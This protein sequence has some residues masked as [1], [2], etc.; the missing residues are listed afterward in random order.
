MWQSKLPLPAES[1][2]APWPLLQL[3]RPVAGKTQ[4]RYLSREQ[5]ALAGEQI[6]QG[7]KFQEQVKQ[8][9]EACEQWANAQ[10]EGFQVASEAAEKGG[11]QRNSKRKSSGTSSAL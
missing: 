4:S 5:A 9:R 1:E 8:Y 3:T 7:H 11:Y 2:G 10:W 6:E